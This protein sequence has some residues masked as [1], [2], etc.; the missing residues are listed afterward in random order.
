MSTLVLHLHPS[1]RRKL[2]QTMAVWFLAIVAVISLASV[3]A[4]DSLS[5]AGVIVGVSL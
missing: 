1:R 4:Q 3:A 5:A 2:A